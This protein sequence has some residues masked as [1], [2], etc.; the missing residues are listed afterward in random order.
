MAALAEANAAGAPLAAV[1]DDDA[2]D[3]FVRMRTGAGDDGAPGAAQRVYWYCSGELY[4]APGGKVVAKVEGYDCAT[5][6]REGPDKVV[7][8]SRKIFFYRDPETHVRR[9]SRAR[10]ALP[11]RKRLTRRNPAE[12]M[13][14]APWIPRPPPPC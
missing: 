2:F 7:Q 8:L 3:H 14:H 1:T 12:D 6:V 4:L 11:A 5:H 9:V 13:L 10:A